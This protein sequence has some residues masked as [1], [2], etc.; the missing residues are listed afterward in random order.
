[1]DTQV[2][3]DPESWAK[4]SFGLS[5]LNDLRRTSRAV[6]VAARLAAN[7]AASLPTQMQ[8]WKESLALYRLLD[9]EEVTFEALMQPH[10]EQTR[11]QIETHSVVLLVQDTTDIDLT[12][13]PKMQGLGQIGNERGRGLYL[14]TVLAVAPESSEVLGCA[15]QE[16][17]VR[18]PAP[19]RETRSQRRQRTER[20]TDVW[21]R[22][23][24]RLGSFPAE[25]TVIHVGDR[26]ADMFPFFQ[27]CRATQTQFLVRAFENR[28]IGPEEEPQRYLIETVRTWPSV[29]HRPFS[30]PGTHGRTA[31][32]TEVQLAFGPVRVMPPRFEKRCGTDPLNLWALRVWEEDTPAGEEALEWI[33]LTSVPTMTLDQAWELIGWYECR[34]IVEEYH[35]CLKTGC[36]LEA[37]QLQTG[38]RFI[39]LLGFLSPLAVRLLRLRDVARRDPER[40]A[41][42]V[43]ET[44][45]LAIVAAQTDQIPEHLTAATFWKAVAQLGGYLGRQSDGPPGWKTLWRGWLRVQTL[46][47]GVHLASHLRL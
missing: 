33:L 40:P 43:V 18:T 28:R 12:H 42:T 1:M 13:H 46:L 2:L 34:W 22:L 47:E 27:A 39:R 29:S 45:V 11:R 37:R 26:A 36:R 38:E 24:S 3:L 10:W 7:P 5:Q 35:Q 20:E 9:E 44:E 41:N 8:T 16:P 23:V 6:K 17:F 4:E 30:V 19:A 32:E 31:R 25:T 14:Q 21:M 15:M